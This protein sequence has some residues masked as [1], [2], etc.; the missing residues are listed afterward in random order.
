MA[1]VTGLT[2]DRM[3]EIEAASVVDGEILAG[4]LILTKHDGSDI[5][6]GSVIGPTGAQGDPG[7]GVPTGGTAGQVLTKDSGTDY[8]TSWASLP[9]VG[10]GTSLPGS[11]TNGDE[12][13]LVDSL[14]APTYSW[15]FRYVSGISGS[16]KWICI[17]GAPWIGPSGSGTVNSGSYTDFPTSNPSLTV[18][19]TGLYIVR[20]GATMYGTVGST[21]SIYVAPKN[22]AAAAS[23]GD[24]ARL[25][26][27]SPSFPISVARINRFTI[28]AGA[29][30]KMQGRSTDSGSVIGVNVFMEVI[31][32][33]VL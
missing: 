26:N 17:G 14:T 9:A 22:G 1:T 30:L 6:A 8:D 24:S 10:I 2:A 20:Y 5:D 29:V 15:R 19:R 13:I 18:P 33:A 4:H 25:E 7:E 32:Q 21:S 12:Y 31:P 11:P 27:I 23:D 3:L 28:S 16:Y